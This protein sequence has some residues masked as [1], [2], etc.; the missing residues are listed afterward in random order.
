VEVQ[1]KENTVE[2]TF[3]YKEN[4]ELKVAEEN[5]EQEV[6]IYHINDKDEN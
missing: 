3:N 4:E 5:E 2:V 1:P 6:K